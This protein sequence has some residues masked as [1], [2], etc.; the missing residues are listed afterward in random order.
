MFGFRKKL[1]AGSSP[2][3]SKAEM[4]AEGLRSK[5]IRNMKY[6]ALIGAIL[7]FADLVMAV[8]GQTVEIRQ[9]DGR[10]YLV[11]PAA[12]DP[13]GHIELDARVRSGS[14]TYENTYD[15]RLD[16]LQEGPEAEASESSR[17]HD[18]SEGSEGELILSEFRAIG[19][20]FNT[21]LS[22][23]LVPLPHQL[24]SG[25]K[26]QWSRSTGSNL[27]LL[28]LL[29]GS[30]MILIY[31]S[32]YRPL[33]KRRQQEQ[34]SVLRHLPVFMNEL[35]LLLNAGL[36]LTRAFEQAVEITGPAD[37]Q[38]YFTRGMRR[39]CSSIRNT[40]ASMHEELH[41]FAKESGV[42]ELMRVSTI[43]SDNINKG[44]ELD[45]KLERESE[46]LWTARK[47]RSEEAGR[48]AE[49]RMTLPLS[50]FLC[51]LIIITVSPA[52]LQ[53]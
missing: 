31:R 16:P 23:Q 24:S 30:S 6:A 26:I 38:D 42:T 48:M 52:L 47:V 43:I 33:E 13:A 18:G 14:E 5:A 22:E 19:S 44:A 53:L 39:I 4:T 29:T 17:E 49:T 7:I 15:I 37:E 11:R 21:D 51:V 1:K 9:A 27:P 28:L 12:S 20:S 34:D 3:A 25:E 40:N 10:L 8:F 36:V 32:R 50:I 45:R 41:R 35:V 2:A 46:A